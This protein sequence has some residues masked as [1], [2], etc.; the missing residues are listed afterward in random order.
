MAPEKNFLPFC[1]FHESSAWLTEF[2]QKRAD[3]I[4]LYTPY[5]LYLRGEGQ[6][7]KEV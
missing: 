7:H 3:L 5:A 1:E 2:T 6:E 4:E